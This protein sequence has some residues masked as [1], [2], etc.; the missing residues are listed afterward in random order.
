[1]SKSLILFLSI[2]LSGC[3]SVTGNLREGGTFIPHVFADRPNPKNPS[4]G[5]DYENFYRYVGAYQDGE[6]YSVN[7]R[8]IGTLKFNGHL[9]V[10]DEKVIRVFQEGE[11][12]AEIS[13]IRNENLL[14]TEKIIAEKRLTK[15]YNS[16]EFYILEDGLKNKIYIYK[17]EIKSPADVSSEIYAYENYLHEQ[18]LLMLK[19]ARA[20]SIQKLEEEY[21]RLGGDLQ[22]AGWR[23][24]PSGGVDSCRNR[25]D[26]ETKLKSLIV[27]T[28][29]N[30]ADRERCLSNDTIGICQSSSQ[31]NSVFMCGG[32]AF[33]ALDN[34]FNQYCYSTDSI[35]IRSKMDVRNNSGKPVSD[36]TF[37]CI[38]IAKSGTNLRKSNHTIYDTWQIKE[39]KRVQIQSP[40]HDQVA[41]VICKAVGWR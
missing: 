35:N 22:S 33:T 15:L 31:N 23:I 18:K 7:P 10:K 36:I 6:L 34:I 13:R 27:E 37:E 24:C 3:Y 32:N 20:A 1:M 26:W 30:Q 38:Q 41:E 19:Q 17:G 4:Q 5:I 39:V 28:K 16:G 14:K 40:K 29:K 12:D 8:W 11:Y 2:V 25:L 9:L 21:K